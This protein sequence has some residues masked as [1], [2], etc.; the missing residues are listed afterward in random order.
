MGKK[1]NWHL[2]VVALF[3][4]ML[5][6]IAVY[7]SEFSYSGQVS[8]SYDFEKRLINNVEGSCCIGECYETYLCPGDPEE[9]ELRC[10]IDKED[11]NACDPG[12]IPKGC[13]LA[14]PGCSFHLED[15]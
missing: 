1:R 5:A 14:S 11:C 12:K 10:G 15:C 6:V 2:L 9:K 4:V 7:S 3:F 13:V 8:K